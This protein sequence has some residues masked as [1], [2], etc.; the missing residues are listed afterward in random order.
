M[1]K[2]S[3]YVSD[4]QIAWLVLLIVLILSVIIRYRFL[5][6]PLERDEGEYAY[7][8]QL[9]L[10]GIPP[11]QEVYNMKLP[12]IYAIYALFLAILG[13]SLQGIHTALLITNAITIITIF[14]LARQFASLLCA[15]ISAASFALLSVGQPVQGVFANA[16]H[17]VIV[18]AIGGLFTTFQGLATSS[19][20]RL[21]SAGLLLGL[22]FVIKQHGFAFI[23]L[24]A[25]YIVFDSL[26]RRPIQW[27]GLTLRSLSFA[28]GVVTVLSC[29]CFIMTWTGVF[30]AFWFWTFD[31][32]S[33]YVSQVPPGEAW[34]R[35]IRNFI[36][37]VHAAPMLWT[38]VGLGFFAV[39]TSRIEKHYKVFLLMYAFFSVLSICP[40]FYF[41]KHYFVLLLPCASLFVGFTISVAWD[42]LSKGYS[43]KVRCG[44]LVLLILACFSQ[45][46]YKQRDFLFDMTPLQVSRAT[47]WPNPFPESLAISKFIRERTSPSD[48][49]AILGSEPQILFY[50]KR[51][52]ASGYIYMYPMMENHD[53]ALQ[54][55]REF[56]R[57]VE[58]K[59]AK[60][61][62]F[63]NVPY[64]WLIRPDSHKE[65][66]QW[67]R[68][69]VHR[70]DLKLVGVVE[71]LEHESI[72]HWEPNVRWPAPSPFWISIF[73]RIP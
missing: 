20:L 57:D 7:A 47:Y 40:S 30:K 23:A 1:N 11:Y 24:A 18:F 42:F 8:G 65:I 6:V 25:V 10:Q 63:V 49:I 39:V 70:G 22:G 60:Y 36:P 69:F 17:F 33:T 26:R 55:Q 13:P 19:L 52:S 64:S 32:A 12:G 53:F 21:F 58:E 5:D 2:V 45:A 9:I 35:F 43:K 16:E 73:E 62:V 3:T 4:K 51:R 28:G 68:G 37:I 50:S 71:V 66:F 41:R 56:I 46:I 54:M 27:R 48:R 38:L 34:P 31:Y 59:N 61:L 67:I 15:V 44:V 72:Y 14:L 29:L